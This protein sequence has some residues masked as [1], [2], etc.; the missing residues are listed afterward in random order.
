M[1]DFHAF[2]SLSYASRTSAAR[3][4]PSSQG[5]SRPETRLRSSATHA[6]LAASTPFTAENREDATCGVNSEFH[7]WA[8]SCSTSVSAT[9]AAQKATSLQRLS[10]THVGP[11]RGHIRRRTAPFPGARGWDIQILMHIL[12]AICPLVWHSCQPSLRNLLRIFAT[13]PMLLAQVMQ[14]IMRQVI[15]TP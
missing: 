10:G 13:M 7:G 11:C 3:A 4:T 9:K 15:Q 14:L 8:C 12:V 6:E 5:S 2:I 1:R